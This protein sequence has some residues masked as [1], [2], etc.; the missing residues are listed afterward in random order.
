MDIT[1][2]ASPH[3]LCI[4]ERGAL[5]SLKHLLTIWPPLG[6]YYLAREIERNMQRVILPSCSKLQG[7]FIY[8]R[9]MR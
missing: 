5:C 9:S 3:N 7:T 8:A 2:P 4:S 6:E 1:R